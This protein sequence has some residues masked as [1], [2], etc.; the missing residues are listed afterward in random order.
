MENYKLENDKIIIYKGK[1][2]VPNS[3]KLKNM[4]LKEM[5]NVP[6]SG[7]LGYQNTITVIKSQ[8]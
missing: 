1:I 5:P 3:Q 4:I 7:H 6:Y 2:Y 8:Y